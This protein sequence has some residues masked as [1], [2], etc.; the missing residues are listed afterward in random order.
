MVQKMYAK[1][2]LDL[3]LESNE[4]EIGEHC[5]FQKDGICSAHTFL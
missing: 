3:A 5:D 2:L 4:M 1:N